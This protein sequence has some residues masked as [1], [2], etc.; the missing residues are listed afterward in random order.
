M[1]YYKISY[2]DKSFLRWFDV[3]DIKEDDLKGWLDYIEQLY[4]EKAMKACKVTKL[5]LSIV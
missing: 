3:S 5:N 2:P 4:G 1:N